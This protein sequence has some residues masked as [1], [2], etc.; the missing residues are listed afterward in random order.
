MK[1]RQLI[2]ELQEYPADK[3]IE[4][5]SSERIEDG[6]VLELES[7][8]TNTSQK[9]VDMNIKGT[10]KK[11]KEEG[12]KKL[13]LDL[14]SL[15]TDGYYYTEFDI[16]GASHSITIDADDKEAFL[17][18]FAQTW[19]EKAEKMLEKVEEE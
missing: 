15:Y 16:T 3:D 9:T 19:R 4:I 1:V 18:A 8:T 6:E 5:V 13:V 11:R 10:R 17:N 14:D 7:I 12:E 2:E